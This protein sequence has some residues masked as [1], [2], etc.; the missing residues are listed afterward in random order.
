MMLVPPMADIVL[1]VEERTTSLCP[2]FLGKEDAHAQAYAL[3]SMS[4]AAGSP[5][6]PLVAG[7]LATK[8]GWGGTTLV[9]GCISGFTVPPILISTSGKHATTMVM[10]DGKGAAR[11]EVSSLSYHIHLEGAH[12]TNL[13]E[14]SSC[15][16]VS[17]LISCPT[18]A[19]NSDRVFDA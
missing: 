6:G 9:L 3:F 15:V 18:K 7:F 14:F 16:G 12:L 5:I 17:V 2:G 11:S 1:A 4:Y 19:A 8:V 10:E 13:I